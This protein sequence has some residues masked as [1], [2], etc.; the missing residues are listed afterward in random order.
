MC[1]YI[2]CLLYNSTMIS[3]IP[4]IAFNVVFGIN[5]DMWVTWTKTVLLFKYGL[6]SLNVNRRKLWDTSK[7]VSLPKERYAAYNVFRILV[8]KTFWLYFHFDLFSLIFSIFC[9]T[10]SVIPLKQTISICCVSA[11]WKTK[12]SSAPSCLQRDLL[13]QDT[14]TLLLWKHTN[15][16]TCRWVH[17]QTGRKGVYLMFGV[18]RVQDSMNQHCCGCTWR[19][20]RVLSV[21]CKMFKVFHHILSTSSSLSLFQNFDII[22]RNLVKFCLV[23]M[24]TPEQWLSISET[25]P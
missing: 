7:M 6:S 17:A 11:V 12:I 19:P 1:C 18:K 9:P 22:I 5:T 2:L 15:T 20:P 8:I 4:H 21:L 25:D 16:G 24:K 13:L 10:V 23:L 14:Q 3:P